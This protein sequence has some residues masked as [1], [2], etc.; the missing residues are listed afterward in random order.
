M[1]IQKKVTFRKNTWGSYC[2]HGSLYHQP[3]IGSTMTPVE[4]LVENMKYVL[5]KKMDSNN[6]LNIKSQIAN[7]WRA[8]YH[9]HFLSVHTTPT[10]LHSQTWYQ[11]STQY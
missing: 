2:W 10:G 8:C 4:V 3:M 9:T 11:T 5:T 1:T 7:N 6:V